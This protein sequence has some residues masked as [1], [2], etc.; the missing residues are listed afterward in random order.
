M[1]RSVT[2][3]CRRMLAALALGGLAFAPAVAQS[4]AAE[5][6]PAARLQTLHAPWFFID[7]DFHAIVAVKNCTDRDIVAVVTARF[8][9]DVGTDGKYE[10]PG[11]L[12]VPA[13]RVALMDLRE[14][15]DTGPNVFGAARSGGVELTYFGGPDDLLATVTMTSMSSKLSFDVPFAHPRSAGSA[16]LDGTWWFTGPEYEAYVMLKNTTDAPVEATIAI[17]FGERGYAERVFAIPARQARAVSI[18]DMGVDLDGA[19][20]GS[21]EITHTGRPG[22]IVAQITTL[23]TVTGIAHGAPFRARARAA[24]SP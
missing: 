7:R 3:L 19:L 21:A 14:V 23:S 5:G 12:R 11:G 24:T 9:S 1:T 4:A 8:G 18:A 22:A 17:S 2:D 10:V 6:A 15:H 16:H 13:G 20:S